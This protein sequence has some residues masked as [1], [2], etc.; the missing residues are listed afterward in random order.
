MKN[1]QGIQGAGRLFR[2]Q[3][4]V[5]LAVSLIIWLVLGVHSA[6]SMVIGGLVSAVPNLYFARVLFRFHGAQQAKNIVNSFYKAEAMK[7]LLTFSLFAIIF[8][9]LNVVPLVFFAGFIVAQMMFWFAPLII[10][11]KQK[12]SERDRNGI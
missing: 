9:Y 2:A 12:R 6:W 4:I 8:K 11:H 3:L 7:L 5:V 10:G 1:E